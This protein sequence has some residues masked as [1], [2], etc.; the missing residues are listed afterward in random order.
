MASQD[1]VGKSIGERYRIESFLGDGGMAAVYKAYDPNL[2][3]DVAIK[4]IHP[5]LSR[6]PEFVRRFEEEA[7]AV[8]R[9]RHP[10]IVQVHDFDQDNGVYYIVFEFVEGES[11]QAVLHHHAESHNPFPIERVLKIGA[12]IGEALAYAHEEGLVHRDIK[13][14]NIMFNRRD[15]AILMDFGIAKMDDAAQHTATGM[16]LGTARY[17]APEQVMGEKVDARTDVYALGVVLFEMVTGRSPFEADSAATLM[18]KHLNAPIPDVRELRADVPPGLIRVIN[19]A[20]AK[21]KSARFQTAVDLVAAIREL[22]GSDSGT[23]T[24]KSPILSV[25]DRTVVETAVS[26]DQLPIKTATTTRQAAAPVEKERKEGEK[27][28]PLW[29]IGGVAIVAIVAMVALFALR[30][31]GNDEP[32]ASRTPVVASSS[33]S[34]SNNSSTNSGS[35]SASLGASGSASSGEEANP[36]SAAFAVSSSSDTPTDV[37]S[38]SS[39]PDFDPL[40]LT[41]YN[42][43][44][45]I[46]TLGLPNS[47]IAHILF[48]VD[49]PEPSINNGRTEPGNSG[50]AN[51]T[52]GPIPY[53]KGD[54]TLYIRYVDGSGT[55]GQI[56]SFDYTVD[57]IVFNYSQQSYDFATQSYPVVFIMVAIDS[58]PNALYTYAYSVDSEALDEGVEG[59]GQGAS[60]I[61]SGLEVGDHVLYVQARGEGLETAVVAYPFTIE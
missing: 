47:D 2:R 36:T 25:D 40:F 19:R 32:P 31:G 50:I 8:A 7:T 57:D 42:Y 5:H 1:W 59:V 21:D 10:H 49:D 44:G 18:M 4:L 51:T 56:Y 52:I 61:L 26:P 3:R 53:E 60:L 38:D 30:G 17:M 16:V 23:A 22:I 9:L 45:L 34:L 13:P 33:I 24:A 55:P 54:H 43:E 15:E 14:A 37:P 11:L 29:L 35:G 6:N 12:Q 28:R 41:I 20:L 39:I 48:S 46:V 58:D 27:K